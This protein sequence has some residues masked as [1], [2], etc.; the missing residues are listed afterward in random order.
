MSRKDA[1]TR[2]MRSVAIDRCV[3]LEVCDLLFYV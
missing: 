3:V 1:L 2:L